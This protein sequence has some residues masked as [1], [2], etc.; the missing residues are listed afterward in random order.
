MCVGPLRAAGRMW[1]NVGMGYHRQ[2]WELQQLEIKRGATA[3]RDS[4]P[5]R[6]HTTLGDICAGGAAARAGDR[7]NLRGAQPL[8]WASLGAGRCFA[9]RCYCLVQS[10]HILVHPLGVLAT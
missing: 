5:R 7:P 4:P 9:T 6:L 2:G 1:A 3:G 10:E 8:N